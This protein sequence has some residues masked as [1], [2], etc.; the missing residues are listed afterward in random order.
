M[1]NSHQPPVC[2]AQDASR[3][4]Y[5]LY[6][7]HAAAQALPG[8]LDDNF[9]LW[10][11][12]GRE[13]VLK[14]AHAEEQRTNLDLQNT[15]LAHLAARDSSLLLPRVC[16]KSRAAPRAGASP[17]PTIHGWAFRSCIVGATLAVA[18]EAGRGQFRQS[19][20]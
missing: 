19:L 16:T 4:A 15:V 11:E 2:S 3:I 18:L 17:A 6:D 7:L 1:N 5:E 14:M 20:T 8:E 10:D 12:A 13:F 9:Y